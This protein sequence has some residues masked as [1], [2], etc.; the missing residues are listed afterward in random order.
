M[1]KRTVLIPDFPL[2][3]KFFQLNEIKVEITS[4]NDLLYEN[5]SSTLTS[6]VNKKE[7][8]AINLNDIVPHLDNLHMLRYLEYFNTI[9]NYTIIIIIVSYHPIAN[10]ITYS[11]CLYRHAFQY[12]YYIIFY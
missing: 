1:K 2:F 12:Q 4:I 8:F 3:D 5:V 7:K 9:F 10:V 11:Q 6:L